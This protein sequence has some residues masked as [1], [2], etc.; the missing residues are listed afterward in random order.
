MATPFFMKSI[1]FNHMSDNQLKVGDKVIYPNGILLDKIYTVK[2]I[3][4]TEVICG[5]DKSS[6][7]RFSKNKLKLINHDTD[8]S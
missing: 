8:I 3:L 1:K 6:L 7:F 4:E 2:H 5:D